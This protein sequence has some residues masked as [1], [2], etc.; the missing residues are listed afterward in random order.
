MKL[1]GLK[2][3]PAKLAGKECK[4]SI[5]YDWGLELLDETGWNSITGGQIEGFKGHIQRNHIKICARCTTP[6][7]LEAGELVDISEELGSED[8]KS[9]L[10]RGQTTL[11]HVKIKDP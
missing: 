8:V 10:A 11:P 1:Q 7:I 2:R 6:Y 3:C 5:F 9:I 4:S